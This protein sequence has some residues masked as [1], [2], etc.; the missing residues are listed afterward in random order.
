[1]CRL[2]PL[3]QAVP[4]RYPQC[5]NRLDEPQVVERK[6]RFLLDPA[7]SR[8]FTDSHDSQ[9][10]G[11]ARSSK[12]Y[13]RFTVD[14]GDFVVHPDLVALASDGETLVA[15]EAKGSGYREAMLSLKSSRALS[16]AFHRTRPAVD[17]SR[18]LR[19][20]RFRLSIARTCSPV[21]SSVQPTRPD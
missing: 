9:F 13:Q 3:R 12:P 6:H 20:D 14:H 2:S 8:L 7:V 1:M 11:A 17:R 16:S 21:R 19:P 18:R 15:V 5:V 4:S 10:G